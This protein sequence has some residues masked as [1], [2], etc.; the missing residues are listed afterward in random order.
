MF[1]TGSVTSSVVVSGTVAK[2]NV[3]PLVPPVAGNLGMY[4]SGRNT[5]SVVDLSGTVA[6]VNV[7]ILVPSGAGNIGMYNSC[8]IT[9]SGVDLSVTVAKDTGLSRR[10]SRRR[11]A[12]LLRSGMP[13]HDI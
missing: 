3:V 7:V 1:N 4:N 8:H 5:F 13:S 12:E 10:A 2:D 6:K 9:F 11:H